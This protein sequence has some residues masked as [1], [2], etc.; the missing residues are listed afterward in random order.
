MRY[1]F[2]TIISGE[3]KNNR[4]KKINVSIAAAAFILLSSRLIDVLGLTSRAV[5][6]KLS[7][8]RWIYCFFFDGPDN[9]W[10]APLNVEHQ[11]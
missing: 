11:F 6:S 10:R 5:F 7:P 1:C 4:H 9:G 2:Q 8:I 3:S